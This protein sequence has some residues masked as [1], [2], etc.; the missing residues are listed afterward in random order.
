[1]A[2]LLAKSAQKAANTRQS[3]VD[4][5]GL[6]KDDNISEATS[7]V[8]EVPVNMSQDRLRRFTAL[9]EAPPKEP[10]RRWRASVR[11][12][13]GGGLG[14]SRPAANAKGER[15]TTDPPANAFAIGSNKTGPLKSPPPPYVLPTLGA[16]STNSYG[17]AIGE[18][19]VQGQPAGQAVGAPVTE[20]SFPE[21]DPFD[22]VC[23][24]CKLLGS[25]SSET[26]TARMWCVYRSLMTV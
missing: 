15:P 26:K 21:D 7:E 19:N 18:D 20:A 23:T 10:V 5:S 6:F 25:M 1:V 17:P 22:H 9:F 13:A 4:I 14:L 11:T 24:A 16:G 12:L 2:G 3:N 8:E